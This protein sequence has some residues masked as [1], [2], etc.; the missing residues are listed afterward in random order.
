MVSQILSQLRTKWFVRIL[1]FSVRPVKNCDQI[2][3][4]NADYVTLEKRERTFL[5][6]IFKICFYLETFLHTQLTKYKTH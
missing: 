6:L 1:I 5:D 3:D 2:S 4:A